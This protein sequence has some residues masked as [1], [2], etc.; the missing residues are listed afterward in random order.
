MGLGSVYIGT[1]MHFFSQVS[2][3]LELP[4]GVFPLVLLCMGYPKSQPTQ[5]KKLGLDVIVHSEK[6]EELSDE[7]L[8]NAMDEKYSHTR[9]QITPKRLEQL[10]L[11]CKEVHGREFAEHCLSKVKENGYIKPVQRYFGLHYLA[12][13]MPTMNLEMQQDMQNQGFRWFH[14]FSKKS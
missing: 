4:Q 9:I 3:M 1:V 14:E 7:D 2:K 8:L 5:R 12:N 11:T 13:E 6:Y 10:E